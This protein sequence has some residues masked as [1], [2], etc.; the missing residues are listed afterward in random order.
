L[1]VPHSP[2]TLKYNRCGNTFL[3]LELYIGTHAAFFENES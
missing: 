3:D 2:G 1:F